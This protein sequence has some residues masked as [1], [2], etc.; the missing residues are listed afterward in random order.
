M[1]RIA[2]IFNAA[3][4]LG[5]L[6]L[7]F[8]GLNSAPAVGQSNWVTSQG[9]LVNG[10]AVQAVAQRLIADACGSG[11]GINGACITDFGITNGGIGFG[12]NSGPTTSP[13]NFFDLGWDAN[14]NAI[15]KIGRNGAGPAPSLSFQINA[16]NYAFPG[17]GNGNIVGPNPST[18][19][20]IVCWNNAVGTLT[21]DCGLPL[22]TPQGRLTLASG[23]PV[24]NSTVNGS[25]TIYWTPYG[26]GMVPIWN[27]SAWNLLS[28]GEITNFTQ[29]LGSNGPAVVANNST[30]DLFI[31][32]NGGTC[33]L[34][35]SPAWSNATTRTLAL[36]SQ[37]GI[38]VN[39]SSI[40][41]GPGA[42][43]GTYVGTIASNGSAT[44]DWIPGGI[45]TA[46]RLMVFNYW[47]RVAIATAVTDA[48]SFYTY[49]S[50]TIRQAGGQTYNQVQ[51]VQA[52]GAS[53]QNEESAILTYTQGFTLA[54]ASAANVRF[55]FGI[56]TTASFNRA[57][58]QVTSISTFGGTGVATNSAV[59][60]IGQVM[61]VR[62]VSA[63]EQSDGTN[64]NTLNKDAAGTLTFLMRM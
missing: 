48:E 57:P 30:Y 26:G 58:F 64:A 2:S 43:L 38:P 55:G 46:A 60:G 1:K 45:S 3:L 18:N 11:G 49:T 27:G 59:L 33:T 7:A 13:Y 54:A 6:A 32:S 35:R 53:N 31:W 21:K 15:I 41:N 37:N 40:T 28:C 8:Q 61:G 34:T 56:D 12:L 44:I 17:T 22:T 63:N 36:T 14:S 16:F 5:L 10:H 24:M 47:N 39:A 20:G 9:V 23:T 51:Y 42:N 4:A 29:F 25:G 19:G 52:G 62:T 50:S